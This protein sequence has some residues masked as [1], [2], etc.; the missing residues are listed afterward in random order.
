MVAEY[1]SI[2]PDNPQPRL[3]RHACDII[4]QG[5][6]GVIP[7]DSAYAL[8]CLTGNKDAVTRISRIRQISKKHNFTLLCRDLSELS[9]YAKVSNPVYRLLRHHTPG[10]YTFILPATREVPRRLLNDRRHTIGIRVPGGA[11]ISAL[12]EEMGEALMSCSLIL[13]DM[14]DP[15]SDPVEINHKI[16]TVVDVIVDGGVLAPFATTVVSFDDA[17][18]PSVVRV[19]QG[20]PAPFEY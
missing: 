13:P 17:S 15:E 7:T 3:V 19:G 1:I 12:L 5:K 6:V 16:G 11:I 4:R 8:C 18:V 14:E 9:V 2:H 10:P 20:D